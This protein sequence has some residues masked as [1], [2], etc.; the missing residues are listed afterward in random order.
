MAIVLKNK[1]DFLHNDTML[2]VLELSEGKLI[3]CHER[4]PET[5]CSTR[6]F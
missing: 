5:M 6:R 3:S 4:R 2:S 1:F